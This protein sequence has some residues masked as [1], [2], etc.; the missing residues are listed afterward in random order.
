MKKVSIVV[1]E[2]KLPIFKKILKENGYSHSIH[3]GVPNCVVLKV[4]IRACDLNSFTELVHKMN[5]A[6]ANSRLN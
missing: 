4:K 3:H 1:D 5:T 6:A 2:W